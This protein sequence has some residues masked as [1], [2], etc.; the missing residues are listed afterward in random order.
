MGFGNLSGLSGATVSVALSL[1]CAATA[2]WATVIVTRRRRAHA[3]CL[4]MGSIMAD[5][6]RLIGAPRQVQ[7]WSPWTDDAREFEVG[8]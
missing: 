5:G 6:G 7:A 4:E 1:L 2:V 3:R 8:E